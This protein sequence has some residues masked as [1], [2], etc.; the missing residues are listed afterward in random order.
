MEKLLWSIAFPGF[1]QLLNRQFLKGVVFLFLEI[2]V[3]IQAHFN[4]V[5]LL[6]FHGEIE[7]A[8]QQTDYQWLLFYP[9]LYCFA[10]WD[11]YRE[12]R[13]GETVPYLFLPF[14]FAAFFVTVGLIYS[15][16]F[17]ILG[18]L[19]GPVWLPMLGL[20]PGVGIGLALMGLCQ[21]RRG[22]R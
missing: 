20:I 22:G 9:C 12:D 7:A 1:G 4:K 3:N 6:S 13:Q 17:T 10:A 5:I 16:S 2:V 18:V 19:F 14:A 21:K 15:P 11:A 8:V